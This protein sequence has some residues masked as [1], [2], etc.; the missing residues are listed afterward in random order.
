MLRP[1]GRSGRRRVSERRRARPSPA[2]PLPPACDQQME[3]S[4]SASFSVF[5]RCPSSKNACIAAHAWE[6]VGEVC[7][8]GLK[9][10]G[11][12]LLDPYTQV[13]ISYGG[14]PVQPRATLETAGIQALCTLHI[15]PNPA[16]ICSRMSLRE[17]LQGLPDRLHRQP[18]SRA[19]ELEAVNAGLEEV[20]VRLESEQLDTVAIGTM[21]GV[22]GALASLS[23]LEDS[24]SI[25]ELAF[26]WLER[27]VAALE[28]QFSLALHE[29]PCRLYPARLALVA[30]L[31]CLVPLLLY[32]LQGSSA[33]QCERVV[34][35]AD[36]LRGFVTLCRDAD[37]NACEPPAGDYPDSLLQ[38]EKL[39]G[40][41]AFSLARL[42]EAATNNAQLLVGDLPGHLEAIEDQREQLDAAMGGIACLAALLSCFD[43]ASGVPAWPGGTAPSPEQLASWLQLKRSLYLPVH[44]QCVRLACLLRCAPGLFGLSTPA[45]CNACHPLPEAAAAQVGRAARWLAQLLGA[46]FICTQA[47]YAPVPGQSDEDIATWHTHLEWWSDTLQATVIQAVLQDARGH[48]MLPSSMLLVPELSPFMPTAAKLYHLG[49]FASGQSE[50]DAEAE[51]WSEDSETLVVQR[52]SDL[53]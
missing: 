47:V 35:A 37:L 41:L 36:A 38:A 44:N 13:Y 5:V 3:A 17:R 53:L 26:T 50:I 32:K 10:K 40:Q 30:A 46:G 8:R 2:A 21:D 7:R 39:L 12:D 27:T 9:R 45:A 34:W 43:T 52:G 51:D 22:F 18:S 42:L 4:G 1:S 49:R 48:C 29:V 31:E 15:H 33:L 25:S 19:E 16:A 6:E 28:T 20:V 24:P 14:R 23:L 11:F